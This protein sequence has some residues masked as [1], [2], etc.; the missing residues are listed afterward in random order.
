MWLTGQRWE[1]EVDV[2]AGWKWPIGGSIELRKLLRHTHCSRDAT[3]TR[4]SLRRRKPLFKVSAGYSGCA[5]F[6]FPAQRQHGF[7]PDFL[8]KMDKLT[9]ILSLLVQLQLNAAIWCL[10]LN[11]RAVEKS[12]PQQPL[13]A[14][15][16][17][18]RSWTLMISFTPFPATFLLYPGIWEKKK[19]CVSI[20]ITR[21]N[22]K[23]SLKTV[24]RRGARHFRFARGLEGLWLCAE[25]WLVD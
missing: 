12:I 22:P 24:P 19:Q 2:W 7:I 25:C 20:K 4:P 10:F 8:P 16:T 11:S 13:Y 18:I 3:E 9:D 5:F 23:R 14:V 17:N 1:A 21:K 6:F 15:R